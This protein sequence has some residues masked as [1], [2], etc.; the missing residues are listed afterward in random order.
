MGGRRFAHLIIWKSSQ[1]EL[2]PIYTAAHF[3]PNSPTPIIQ[4]APPPP[5]LVRPEEFMHM[6]IDD[7]P[8]EAVWEVFMALDD[9]NGGQISV[10]ELVA[11][12]DGLD[13]VL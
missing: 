13:G 2:G 10:D 7:Y 11:F 8:D 5:L 3:G 12:A 1:E 6:T 9:D 4:F